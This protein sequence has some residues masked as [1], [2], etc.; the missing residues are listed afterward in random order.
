MTGHD[1]GQPVAGAGG[2]DSARGRGL[3]DRAGDL[4]IGS[5]RAGGNALQLLPDPEL[6]CRA[7]RVER[8]NASAE[9]PRVTV[10]SPRSVVATSS[11]PSDVGRVTKRIRRPAPPR[12][13]AAGVI[14]IRARAWSYARLAEVYPA[15]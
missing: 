13:Y 15:S 7:L 3:A 6:E 10:Q 9:S 14:P 1:D 12:R 8:S 5:G 4:A 11:V 2:G